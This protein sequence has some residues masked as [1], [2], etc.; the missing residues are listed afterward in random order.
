MI[1]CTRWRFARAR[2][3]LIWSDA[4]H[5]HPSASQVAYAGRQGAV[6]IRLAS[7]VCIWVLLLT[8]L[9]I[10]M[11]LAKWLFWPFAAEPVNEAAVRQQ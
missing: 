11:L 3:G 8:F 7:R 6:H 5:A 2:R 1:G 9:I 4:L 10:R